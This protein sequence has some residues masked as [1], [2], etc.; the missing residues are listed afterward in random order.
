MEQQKQ[1]RAEQQINKGEVEMTQ[2]TNTTE[3][4]TNKK[5]N[6]YKIGQRIWIKALKKD[7]FVKELDVKNYD[8][9]V[10]HF[11]DGESVFTKLKLW[12]IAPIRNKNSKNKTRTYKK[13]NKRVHKRDMVLFAKV[14]PDAKIP[15]KDRENAGYDFYACFDQ[16]EMILPV[17]KPTLV[18]TGIASSMSP[19]YYL[20]L[21][22]ERGS[23]GKFGMS[24]LS[25]VVDSGYRGEIFINIVPTYKTV[26]IS[27]AVQEVVETDDEIVYPYNKAIAQGTIEFVPDV[28]IKEIP[29]EKLKNIPSKRGTG[30]L[31][32]SGK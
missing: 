10:T 17:G 23:T 8:V 2:Q 9:I 16:D 5:K 13:Q 7:G 22:H 30:A 21:K 24:V 11:E 14:R 27:K 25:G 31:G 3:K 4:K 29:Y 18:P 19:K 1:I 6:Y 15:S 20:N 32:S 12:E 26:V 28:I